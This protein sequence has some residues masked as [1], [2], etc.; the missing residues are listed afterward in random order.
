MKHLGG[1]LGPNRRTALAVLVGPHRLGVGATAATT[2]YAEATTGACAG[3]GRTGP[4]DTTCS[5]LASQN[6]G[7]PTASH[8]TR[9]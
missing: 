4:L 8:A 3:L 6:T 2:I 5:A 9:P 7:I 1:L